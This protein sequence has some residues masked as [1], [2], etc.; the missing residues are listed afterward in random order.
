MAYDNRSRIQPGIRTSA[1]IDPRALAEDISTKIHVLKP[2]ATPIDS[3]F[4]IFGRG[5]KPIGHKV[6]TVQ[7]HQFD[8]IDFCSQ[9]VMGGNLPAGW[10]A[11]AQLRLDQ[12]SRPMTNGTMWYAPGDKLH[13]QAT[14]QT[15]II[16]VTP[17]D[18]IAMNDTSKFNDGQNGAVTGNSGDRTLQHWVLVKNVEQAPLIAFD[19]SVVVYL[20]NVLRESQRIDTP[21]RQRD[22]IYDC[23]YVEHKDATVIFTEDQAT[24]VKTKFSTPDLNFQ[25]EQNL[26]EFKKAVDYNLMFSER[27]LDS[28]DPVRLTRNMRGLLNHIETNVAVYNPQGIMN[29]EGMMQNFMLEQA[30]RYNPNS[31]KKV[32]ICGGGF[33]AQFN[34][35]F[36][37]LR[38]ITQMSNGTIGLNLDTYSFTGFELSMT[39][40][41][42]F[43][44]DTP[45]WHWC[46]VID[47]VEAEMRMVKDYATKPMYQN[48]D[49]R[50]MKFMVEWQGT[51]AWNIEQAHA[52]LKTV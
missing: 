2:E 49:E 1:S 6:S 29:F 16:Y 10:D 50:D 46:V 4:R 23:N 27:S 24:W 20:G 19:S 39:R 13:I 14:G 7:Y 15:V 25:Q 32:A 44:Q 41:D 47:P 43:A 52:L 40:S 26:L 45:Y 11:F 31:N 8:P 38:R 36:G 30:F 34:Q 21:S 37:A 9:T 5:P 48:G 22:L 42:I 12:P 33:L 3:I 35:T 17:A 51:V 18:S 28:R